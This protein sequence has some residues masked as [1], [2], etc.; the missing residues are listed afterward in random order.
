MENKNFGLTEAS[1]AE[2][3]ND[4]KANDTR[5]FLQVFLK[6]FEETI[7]YVKRE[8]GAS[9]EDAYDATMDTL[10]E[11]RLRFVNGKLRYGNLRFLFTKMTTQMYLRNKKNNQPL[12]NDITGIP[13]REEERSDAAVPEGFSRAWNSLGK[14]CKELLTQHYYGKMKLIEIAKITSKNPT[15]V[16]KQKE[17]CVKKLKDLMVEII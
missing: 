4:L 8:C 12:T 17:R 3:I 13:E 10:L 5:F 2:M 9:H 16:R 7:L 14:N 6:Q 1:F 15:A 11:F